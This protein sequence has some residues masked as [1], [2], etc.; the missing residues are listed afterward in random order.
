MSA[1]R[2]SRPQG[3]PYVYHDRD[4]L[5]LEFD[6]H[7]LTFAFT[8]GGLHKALAHIPDI[9]PQRMIARNTSANRVLPKA[10]VAKT[11]AKRREILDIDK[12]VMDAA[13]EVVR[14]MDFDK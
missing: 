7:V 1:T 13:A 6:G 9:T 5:Y 4:N 3:C 14:G 8:S 12:E 11:T 10:K 2:A